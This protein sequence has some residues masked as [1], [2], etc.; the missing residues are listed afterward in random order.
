MDTMRQDLRYAVRRLAAAPLFSATVVLMLALGIG[1]N[2]AIFSVVNAVLLRPLPYPEAGAL[3]HLNHV[4]GGSF[5]AAVSARGYAEY[6]AV[7]SG[8]EA[9]GAH[10]PWAANLTEIGE[11]ERVTAARVT[12]SYFE[13]LGHAPA[14]GR[15]FRGEEAEP[16]APRVVVV[17]DGF[18]RRR[19]GGGAGVVGTAVR[20]NGEPYEIVGVMPPGY[21]D[22]YAPQVE[23]WAPLAFTPQQL[24][25]G[26]TNEFLS[27]V[28]RMRTGITVP[29]LNAELDA[30]GARLR[31]E[32]DLPD[33]WAL[34]V[35][36]L[37][38]LSRAGLRPMLLILMGAVGLVLLIACAN[39]ANLLLA[40]AS[41]RSREVAIRTAL[42]AGRWRVVRQ[43]LTESVVLAAAGGAL[44]LLLAAGGVRV[45]GVALPVSTRAAL[46]VGL[47]GGVLAFAALLAVATG[48]LFGLA[49][50]LQ[51]AR[52]D[53]Q[54]TLRDGGRSGRADRAGQWLR[55]ALVA[56]E[57]ALALTLL[58]GAGLLLQS[59]VRLQAVDP[60]FE[61]ERL[62]TFDLFLPPTQY[63]DAAARVAFF[64]RVLDALR[65]VP[66]VAS[67]GA[68][69]VLPFSGRGSTSSFAI[70]GLPAP[71]DGQ[72]PWG[73]NR[74]VSPGYFETMGIPLLEG[75]TFSPADAA[76]SEPVAVVDEGL[77]R[78]YWPDASAVG[79]RLTYGDPADPEATW[80]RIVGVVGHAAQE[81]LDGP[82]RVQVYR[83]YRQSSAA[84]L[85]VVAR[86]TLPPASLVGAARAAVQSVDPDMPLASVGTMDAQLE[87]SIGQRR[88]AAAL[89]G[90]FAG[91]ALALACL[92]IYGVMAY[93]VAQRR[94]EIGL[95]IA[96]GAGTASVVG[97]FV[98]QGAVLVGTGL[99]L[100][101]AGAFGLTRLLRSQL[102]G[103]DATDPTTFG[104]VA[105]LLVGTAGIAT[106]L[107]ARRAAR[108]DP[109]TALR[110]E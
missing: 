24:S 36:P 78:R 10:A 8:F 7:V 44:G 71:P 100:G 56:G 95:R 21:R 107:P 106:W 68:V 40:R 4:Y 62:L 23:V 19:L 14:Q 33:A 54:Q 18:W 42:G 49:P 88:L 11:P 32:Q 72:G 77:A 51:L 1:A 22:V 83:T 26:W 84:A 87:A 57:M 31:A 5:E 105:L 89:L 60:G 13:V 92:G 9:L 81:G 110:D 90:G 98:R 94:R 46:D 64:D 79:R 2:T 39:V 104:A 34:R 96:L 50:A 37:A 20:L 109:L 101:L 17:T 103:V 74:R 16:G 27:V 48:V 28:G 99:I 59:F 52:S 86:T 45:L 93:I 67:V 35:R 55:R 61:S 43:L 97:L 30:L 53:V 82:P 73:D 69:D 80:Y 85:S 63:G 29:T 66:G 108:L 12:P 65:E 102:Y 25:G 3:V 76:A 47:D 70:E 15:V 75:R 58:A 6:D 41:G 91:L 38:E